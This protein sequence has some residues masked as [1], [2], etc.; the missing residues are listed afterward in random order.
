VPRIIDALLVAGYQRLPYWFFVHGRN[1]IT[2]QCSRRG[3]SMLAPP[4]V[5]DA[6]TDLFNLGDGEIIAGRLERLGWRRRLSYGFTGPG[7]AV[8]IMSSAITGSEM[9]LDIRGPKPA[10][11]RAALDS[12]GVAQHADDVGQDTRASARTVPDVTTHSL[13]HAEVYLPSAFTG[14]IVAARDTQADDTL[15]HVQHADG[16]VE[17]YWRTDLELV[18]EQ[19]T[20][21]CRCGQ[22]M[23]YQ[24]FASRTISKA[25]VSLPANWP[26]PNEREQPPPHVAATVF[27]TMSLP[28]PSAT[29][30]AT[31]CP[32]LIWRSF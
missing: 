20:K 15:C 13:V 28:S 16:M 14:V 17:Q 25:A 1:H 27:L 22:R 8:T 18:T 23:I 9:A 12:L 24:G 6:Y 3:M 4:D 21:L 30:C 32:T 10:L 29:L 31:A 5:W 26:Q 7:A 2:L 11:V 19:Q